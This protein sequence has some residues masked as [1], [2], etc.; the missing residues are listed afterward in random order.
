MTSDTKVRCTDCGQNFDD[1]WM[2]DFGT[3]CICDGFSDKRMRE[4]EL[5]LH[6]Y[7]LGFS[8]LPVNPRSKVPC[9]KWKPLQ[10]ERATR[11][12]IDEWFSGKRRRVGIITGCLSGIVA[13]DCDNPS[14]TAPQ[15][16]SLQQ[17]TKRG[18]HYV[19]RHPGRHVKN[20]QAVGGRPI[21][22][23]GDGGYILA[24]QD[25]AEWSKDDI[26]SAPVYDWAFT[27]RG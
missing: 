6:L 12:Q 4:H 17:A 22:F 2:N 24:Y 18:R 14:E 21:D 1:M 9:V 10:T 26:E 25:S 27:E 13:V 19:Y 5:A 7:D 15:E 16:T 3:D 8:V 11:D 23:R 20:R